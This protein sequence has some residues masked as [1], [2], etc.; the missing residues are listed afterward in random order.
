M[1]E[2]LDQLA[3]NLNGGVSRRKALWQFITGLGAAGVLTGRKAAA[4]TP[5]VN[6]CV[7][8]CDLQATNFYN[9]CMA[10]SV[11]CGSLHNSGYCAELTCVGQSK[12]V[13]TTIIING[14]DEFGTFTCVP[15]ISTG[16]P[17]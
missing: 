9:V 17:L 1:R 14:S 13:D 4:A 12:P 15:T 3:K 8:F 5:P 2:S 11:I 6:V 16:I 7:A 10:A